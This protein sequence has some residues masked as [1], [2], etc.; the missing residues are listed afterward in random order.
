MLA[1]FNLEITRALG[2]RE[3][4]DA[5]AR[6]E[7]SGG[8]DLVLL[9]VMMPELDGL[10]VL[11]EMRK[12]T[13]PEQRVPILLVTAL[14]AREDRIRGL[15]AGADDFLTKPLDPNEVRCRVRTFLALRAAQ[16]MLQKRAAELEHLQKQKA[17]LTRMIVHDLKNP[18]ASVGSNLG[19]IDKRL[20]KLGVTD[21]DLLE[22]LDDSRSGAARLLALIAGLIDVE[23]AE[24]GQ[25]VVKKRPM[26]LGELV[27]GVA[28][29]HSK[30]A[31]ERDIAIA[32]E[33]DAAVE[34]E[35]DPD[36]VS[37]VLEN[38]VQNATR[39]TNAGGRIALMCRSFENGDLELS[40]CN[41][42]TPIAASVRDKVFDKHT[43]SEDRSTRGMNLGLGLYFCRLAARA[44]GGEV[45]VDSTEEWPTRFFLRLPKETPSLSPSQAPQTQIEERRAGEVTAT[46][47]TKVPAAFLD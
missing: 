47:K 25:L 8:Y 17:E 7:A 27:E 15:E 3:A 40:V 29:R 13:P 16:R 4:I 42:G 38:L 33:A 37:R 30:E 6:A 9:D 46:R 5:F 34:F 22:A 10:T 18:L 28:R 2:G 14:N 21:S 12:L 1:S 11:G 44:H 32:V 39:Y 26:R 35:L 24:T 19:W 36:L 23:K 31:K 41:T 20:R 45:G 43:S